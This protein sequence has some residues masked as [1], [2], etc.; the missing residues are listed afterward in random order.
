V[1]NHPQRRAGSPP[2]QALEPLICRTVLSKASSREPESI[3][4]SSKTS[5]SSRLQSFFLLHI[6]SKSLLLFGIPAPAKECIVCPP[7]CTAATP[8]LAQIATAPLSSNLL[9]SAATM[10]VIARLFPVPAHPV[11]KTLRPLATRSTACCWVGERCIRCA[12][13]ALFPS[14]GFLS[15][16]RGFGALIGLTMPWPLAPNPC[17]GR[18]PCLSISRI[19]NAE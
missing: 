11:K 15:P 14:P 2:K 10:W 18:C 16:R 5:A 8:V 13:C 9:R 19:A 12:R 7:S 3:D 1:Q 6:L 17:P 4:T